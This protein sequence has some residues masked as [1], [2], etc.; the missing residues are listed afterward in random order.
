MNH[1]FFGLM[2]LKEELEV[3]YLILKLLT[4][5]VR[6]T[7]LKL[8]DIWIQRVKRKLKDLGNIILKNNSF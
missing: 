6:I 2:K 8:R 4:Q 5:M 7:G 3:T 1:K